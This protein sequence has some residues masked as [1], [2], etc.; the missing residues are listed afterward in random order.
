MNTAKPHPVT[1]RKGE[2]FAAHTAD[3]RNPVI[4][5]EA[6]FGLVV[7][8]A[9]A[10]PEDLF[11]SPQRFIRQKLMHRTGTSYHLPTGGAVY[12]DTG[13]IEI[14]TP[15]IEIGMD[16]AAQA[17]RSLWE[18]LQF[19]RSELDAWEERTG[20]SVR[21]VGFSA[22]YNVSFAPLGPKNARE[23][24]T[25]EALAKLLA[26]I[27][28]P[29]VLLLSANKASTGIGVRPRPGRIE[30]TADFTPSAALMIAT[31]AVV[32]AVAREVMTWPSYDLDE[33]QRRGFPVI[34]GYAP[35]KHPSRQGWKADAKAYPSSPIS[36]HPDE[37]IWSLV[38]GFEP[39]LESTPNGELVSL[40]QIAQETVRRFRRPILHIAGP[41][42]VRLINRVLLGRTPA[43]LDLDAR[44]ESYEHVGRTC[45]WDDL[46][47][48]RVLARSRYER[49]LIR[50]IAG[51]HFA[52][53]GQRLRPV[54]LRG[55]SEVVFE[56][57]SGS[58]TAFPLDVLAERL[59]DWSG[60]VLPE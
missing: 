49:V 41:F 25:V 18:S 30:I 33:L 5:L 53:R 37:A 60:G 48:E 7:D 40:R 28:P 3:L 27:L 47:P 10:R 35:I 16:S 15:V 20:R 19:L 21:L 29:P 39:M 50:A 58:R 59:D 6:E 1:A 26:Y 36:A 24:R 51:Q 55:W 45:A 56:D 9:V 4:G 52:Y 11:G 8:G 17:G 12:F 32:A 2:A 23:G 14:A 46:F 42:T 57:P 34:E 43:L 44:P 22:H 38:E 13:V 31:T 54:Q